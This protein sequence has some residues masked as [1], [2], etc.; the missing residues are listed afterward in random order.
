[1]TSVQF[2]FLKIYYSFPIP[3]P[4]L[5]YVYIKF[6]SFSFCYFLLYSF[7]LFP[8]Q[9]QTITIIVKSVVFDWTARHCS[10]QRSYMFCCIR[11]CW[12]I[13]KL[14]PMPWFSVKRNT[15]MTG[16]SRYNQL[17]NFFPLNRRPSF[18]N[19]L[20]SLKVNK[21]QKKKTP[22]WRLRADFD[23][24]SVFH[25]L[26]IYYSFL[27]PPPPIYLDSFSFCYFLFYSFHLFALQR[28]TITMRK[29]KL[30]IP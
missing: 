3:I 8:L 13:S 28:Q 30:A 16:L 6:L 19:L 14:F 10:S 17:M 5:I 18:R 23:V 11:Y 21:Q 15:Y 29:M 1:M 4:V 22:S 26:K 9:R 20:I 24:T 25:F 27:T 12:P 2:H 7:H